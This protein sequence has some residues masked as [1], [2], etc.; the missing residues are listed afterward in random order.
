MQPY[1]G[2]HAVC[3]GWGPLSWL[4]LLVQQAGLV[5]CAKALHHSPRMQVQCSKLQ[6][7]G[8]MDQSQ[9]AHA[10]R[11]TACEARSRGCT[12]CIR[13]PG[14]KAFF[15]PRQC[16]RSKAFPPH[17]LQPTPAC[18][19]HV[20]HGNMGA[21]CGSCMHPGAPRCAR[22]APAHT[23]LRHEPTLRP[24][25]LCAML[26]V[27]LGCPLWSFVASADAAAWVAC[28]AA[29]VRMHA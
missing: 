4:L 3:P 9:H 25:S 2:C 7:H 24:A 11:L 19:W 26:C 15:M 21:L 22:M 6:R 20:V 16:L 29:V 13:M 5:R 8:D 23:L 1:L 12:A 17:L 14:P 18:A 28:V 27:T 10:W